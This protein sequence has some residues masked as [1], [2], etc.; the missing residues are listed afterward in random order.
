MTLALLAVP[1]LAEEYRASVT[2]VSGIWRWRAEQ[3]QPGESAGWQEAAFDDSAWKGGELPAAGT[4]THWFR[5]RFNPPAA[6]A[7][8]FVRV[9][10]SNIAPEARLWL[11]GQPVRLDGAREADLTPHINYTAL[12]TIAIAGPVASFTGT[13]LI[14]T[15]RVFIAS[16][17]ARSMFNTIDLKVRVRNTLDNSSNVEVGVEIGVPGVNALKGS[18]SSLIPANVEQVFELR[19]P[20]PARWR[21]TL[22]TRALLYKS[23]EALEGAYT[24]E[25]ISLIELR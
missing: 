10:F 24:Y 4:G 23:A 13:R 7:S 3:G 12:N 11:N 22:R 18:A 19:M 15:P 1:L 6:S 2:P 20:R 16:L 14:S 21:G 25:E 9:V 8:R 17:E 5:A